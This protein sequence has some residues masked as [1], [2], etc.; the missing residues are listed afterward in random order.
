M[1]GELKHALQQPFIF[2]TGLSA[3]I[4]SAW[5]LGTMFSGNMPQPG[6]TGHFIFWIVPAVLIAFA[7]DIGQIS[8]SAEIRAGQHSRAKYGTFVTLALATYYLQFIYIVHHMPALQIAAG[9]ALFPSLAELVRNA[10]VWVIPA[11]LPIST[12]LYTIGTDDPPVLKPAEGYQLETPAE[13]VINDALLLQG[14]N[15]HEPELYDALCDECGWRGIDYATKLAAANA[16]KAHKMHKH[17][18]KLPTSNGN[19]HH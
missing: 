10:A 12:I 1:S 17:L 16:V 4:H 18:V 13:I 5:S 3:G 7:I 6:L 14:E 9:V 8:T 15:N 11:L 2:A 19:H